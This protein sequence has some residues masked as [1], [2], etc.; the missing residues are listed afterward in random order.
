MP[1][2]AASSRATAAR[3]VPSA[4]EPTQFQ[5]PIG[6][7][8]SS[9]L[10]PEFVDIKMGP[11][12]TPPPEEAATIFVPSADTAKLVQFVIGALVNIHVCAAPAIV[13]NH[14]E[15]AINHGRSAIGHPHSPEV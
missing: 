13:P 11:G 2:V 12:H 4:E 6:A 7:L 1:L 5:T 15:D 3:C 14:N 9:Q 8:V 10:L